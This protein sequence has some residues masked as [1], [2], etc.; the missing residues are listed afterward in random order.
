MLNL[1]GDRYDLYQTPQ[2]AVL[3]KAGKPCGRGWIAETKKCS[4]EKK[5]HAL[6]NRRADLER[7]AN[8]KREAKGLRPKVKTAP[9][10]I[11]LAE[12]GASDKMLEESL[13]QFGGVGM[14]M[15]IAQALAEPPTTFEGALKNIVPFNKNQQK[16]LGELRAD[17]LD[18]RNLAKAFTLESNIRAL[19]KE[20]GLSQPGGE[21][22]W[23]AFG[24]QIRIKAIADGAIQGRIDRLNRLYKGKISMDEAQVAA[25]LTRTFH[26]LNPRKLIKMPKGTTQQEYYQVLNKLLDGDKAAIKKYTVARPSKK[27]RKK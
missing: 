14:S 25:T 19:A 6:K 12:L 16:L 13:E 8:T 15:A 4:P 3:V 20:F 7:Y 26:A 5:Q 2:G 21:V 27:K 17:L 22:D 9:D 11:S 18:L 1:A 10:D 24:E 23:D